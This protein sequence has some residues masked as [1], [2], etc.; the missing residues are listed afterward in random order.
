MGPVI[1]TGSIHTWRLR[2]TLSA[3]QNFDGLEVWL[4]RSVSVLSPFWELGREPSRLL[5]RHLP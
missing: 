1:K 5:T 4:R 3:H 2:N